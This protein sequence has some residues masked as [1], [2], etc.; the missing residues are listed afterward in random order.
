MTYILASITIF[1]VIT[2]ATSLWMVRKISKNYEE[3]L[4]EA[5]RDAYTLG[6][7][8]GMRSAYP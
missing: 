1:C 5:R 3:D 6:F 4:A 2:T 8:E 7:E